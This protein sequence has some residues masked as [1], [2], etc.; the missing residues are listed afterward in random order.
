MMNG[1]MT[2]RSGTVNMGSTV[3]VSSAIAPVYAQGLLAGRINGNAFD[4]SSPNPAT[5]LEPNLSKMT[6]SGDNATSG[7]LWVDNST[8]VYGGQFYQAAEGPVS[9]AENFDDSVLLTIDGQTWLNNQASDS[10]TTSGTRNLTKGWHQFEVRF[11]QGG[12]GVGGV[13]QAGQNFNGGLPLGY[14]PQGRGQTTR[15][16]FVM[17]DPSL[18]RTGP[19]GQPGLLAGRIN[20]NA[21]DTTSPNPATSVAPDLW[22]MSYMGDSASSGGLWQDNSTWVFSG[23]FLQASDGP[24]SFAENF[25]DSVLL[26]IDGQ[27]ILN[28][29]SYNTPTSGTLTLGAGWHDFEARFGQGAGYLLRVAGVFPAQPG[30][31]RDRQSCHRLHGSHDVSRF[32]EVFQKGAA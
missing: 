20:G 10:P 32:L 21:F 31:G 29:G 13:N 27:T 11:G 12:G 8:W 4:T 19:G 18:F 26:K 14:D 16:N 28:N 9:F 15:G 6:Y 1:T 5:S 7:T 24:V 22:S 25:D 23:Q 2:V 30:F 17:P 3:A